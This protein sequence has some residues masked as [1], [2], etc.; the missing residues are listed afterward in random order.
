[1]RGNEGGGGEQKVEVKE[2]KRRR[3]R[4]DVCYC[5]A[6]QQKASCIFLHKLKKHTLCKTHW[7]ILKEQFVGQLGDMETH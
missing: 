2:R 3:R 7:R 5:E 6:A 4:E 1:M